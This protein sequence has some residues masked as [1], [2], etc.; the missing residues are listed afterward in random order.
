MVAEAGK[1]DGRPVHHVDH[2]DR[3]VEAREEAGCHEVPPMSHDAVLGA[4]SLDYYYHYYYYF[5]ELFTIMYYYL[6]SF[7]I[8]EVAP[9]SHDGSA[10]CG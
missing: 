10:R 4:V 8:I 9:M 6:L 7:I 3:L 5:L 2:P 1:V